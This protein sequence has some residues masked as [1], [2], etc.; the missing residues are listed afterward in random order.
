[1]NPVLACE[2]LLTWLAICYR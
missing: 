2:T 1:M